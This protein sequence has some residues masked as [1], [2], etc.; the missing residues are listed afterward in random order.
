MSET[1]SSTGGHHRVGLGQ[2][3]SDAAQAHADRDQHASDRDQEQPV[4]LIVPSGIAVL[5]YLTPLRWGGLESPGARRRSCQRSPI[6]ASTLLGKRTSASRLVILG[7]GSLGRNAPT[8]SAVQSPR[9]C[10]SA[11]RG[12]PST[13]NGGIAMSATGAETSRGGRAGVVDRPG[14]RLATETKA[15]YKTTEFMAYVAVLAAIL[16]SAA[17]TKGTGAHVDV[18]KASQAWLYITV[19]TAGY[20][21]SRGLAKSG[22]REAYDEGRS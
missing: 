16:I 12:G 19:L 22:S 17:V 1:H 3:G 9:L 4:Q 6:S 11:R 20:M 18:F 5:Q 2:I 10:F 7:L 14:R 8:I 15:S 13:L 21:I